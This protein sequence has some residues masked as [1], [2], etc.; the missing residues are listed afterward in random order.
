MKLNLP[1]EITDQT[2]R[3][4]IEKWIVE[5]RDPNNKKCRGQLI[6]AQK[7]LSPRYEYCVIGLACKSQN[8][9][10]SFKFYEHCFM[11]FD[12]HQCYETETVPDYWFEKIFGFRINHDFID[13]TRYSSLITLNDS[14]N[15]S[16]ERMSVIL[17]CVLNRNTEIDDY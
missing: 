5:L 15:Y 10:T 9:P 17:E 14:N 8:I 11:F 6:T 7:A 1:S 13:N 4:N 2:Q 16:F 12:D 3:K